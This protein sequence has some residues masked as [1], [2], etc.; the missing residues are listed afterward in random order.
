[1]SS[2]SIFGGV[3]PG[4]SLGVWEQD[5]R[6]M[7]PTDDDARAARPATVVLVVQPTFDRHSETRTPP[8]L[9]SA[10]C[11]RNRPIGRRPALL[12]SP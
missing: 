6:S 3:A 8:L 7:R 12:W 9:R 4:R 10:A 5:R 2:A 11:R 1:M